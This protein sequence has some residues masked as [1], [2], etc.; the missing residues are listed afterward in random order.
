MEVRQRGGSRLEER[1]GPLMKEALVTSK[2]TCSGETLLHVDGDAVGSRD[3][4][5]I[6]CGTCDGDRMRPPVQTLN[7]PRK[8]LLILSIHV[9]MDMRRLGALGQV[10]LHIERVADLVPIFGRPQVRQP[11]SSTRRSADPP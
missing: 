11:S 6:L 7:L 9:C 10:V 1:P 3:R 5:M 4:I 8:T 2:M